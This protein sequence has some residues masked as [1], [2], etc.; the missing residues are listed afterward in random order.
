MKVEDYFLTKNPV[1]DREI[2]YKII[3]LGLDFVNGKTR[4]G[5]VLKYKSHKEIKDI[6]A[7]YDDLLDTLDLDDSLRV[8]E[9]IGEFSISQS[10]VNYL[11]FPDSGNALPALAADIYSKFLNQNLIAFDRSAPIAT[12]IEIQLIEWLRGL[13]GYETKSFKNIKKLSDVSGMWTTG[14]HMSNHIAIMAAL[15]EK[16]PIVK[17]QGLASLHFLPKII[18]AGKISH[19]SFSS[20]MHHLGL[21]QEN[22]INANTNPDFTTDVT[23]VGELLKNPEKRKEIFMVV[24]VAGNSRTSSLDNIEELSKVCKKYGIWLH[25]DA[26]HGGSL[27][28]SKKLKNRDL[29][30][31]EQADSVSLDPHKGLFIT[32][33]SSYVVFKKRDIPV[34][35]TRYEGSVRSGEAWDLGYITPFFGSRG[36]DSLKLWF[37]LKVLGRDGI[38]ELVEKRDENARHAAELIK[39]THLFTLFHDMTFYRLVFV[40]QPKFLSK[41]LKKENISLRLKSEIKKCVDYFTHNLNQEIYEE[42]NLILDEFKLHDIGNKTK[43]NSGEERFYVM[44]ITIGNPLF[45]NESLEKSLSVLF[46]KAESYLDRYKDSINEILENG[47]FTDEIKTHFGPA[48][49]E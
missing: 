7:Q 10:D 35:F 41:I 16:F 12:F 38:C 17:S 28:F 18:L 42:G 5:K 3:D 47:K 20:A 21:G 36:F 11:A 48:G 25:V 26:C 46:K 49:W 34:H 6:I 37:M 14:G 32:Y 9:Q 24:C 27:I 2:F 1:K 30:G 15:N 29:K 13:I 19:Y 40:Y 33:P 8:L 45:T 39:K 22:I 31:I 43:L 23:H 44:S 4:G